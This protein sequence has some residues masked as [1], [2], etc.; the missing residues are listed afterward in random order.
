MINQKADPHTLHNF[1]VFRLHKK[2]YYLG[3][4][5]YPKGTK[6]RTK[7]L[8]I[9]HRGYHDEK[10]PSFN[11][12][13]RDTEFY[14]LWNTYLRQMVQSTPLGRSPGTPLSYQSYA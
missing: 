14:D 11:L 8:N 7:A 12:P 3:D 1:N 2:V 4:I 6:L 5:L 13:P 10:F 9:H